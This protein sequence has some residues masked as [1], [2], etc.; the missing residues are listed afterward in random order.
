V[1]L[2]LQSSSFH[3]YMPVF[4]PLPFAAAG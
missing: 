1:L 3:I 4:R 2:M